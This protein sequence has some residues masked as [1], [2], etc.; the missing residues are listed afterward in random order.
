VV[1]SFQNAVSQ[2]SPLRSQREHQISG[3]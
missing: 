1:D 3:E 2:A